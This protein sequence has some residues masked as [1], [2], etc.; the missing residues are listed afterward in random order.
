[1][2]LAFT[3]NNL[4]LF[5]KYKGFDPESSSTEAGSNVNGFAGFTYPAL[6]SYHFHFKHRILKSI[7]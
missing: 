6:R 1:V 3:G 7:P 4:L 5:T 2:N